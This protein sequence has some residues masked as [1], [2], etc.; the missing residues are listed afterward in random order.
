MTAF[1]CI[2]VTGDAGF[3]GVRLSA[4]LAAAGHD[5]DRALSFCDGALSEEASLRPVDVYSRSRATAGL[6][7]PTSSARKRETQVGIGLT[8][9]LHDR[10]HAA[11]DTERLARGLCAR[12]HVIVAC[13]RWIFSR[14][15]CANACSNWVKRGYGGMA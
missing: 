6:P 11:G 8:S 5:A 9:E 15:A 14:F 2:V 3:V 12:W 10:R 13:L 4:V 1:K 7:F